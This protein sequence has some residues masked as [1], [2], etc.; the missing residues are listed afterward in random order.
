LQTGLYWVIQ[1]KTNGQ[2]VG[3]EMVLGGAHFSCDE[4]G[5]GASPRPI[6]AFLNPSPPRWQPEQVVVN[7][8]LTNGAEFGFVFRFKDNTLA[9]S[10]WLRD[11]RNE[12][13]PSALLSGASWGPAR[14]ISP[15]T[16]QPERE[17]LLRGYVLKTHE[18]EE[19][20]PLKIYVYPFHL[21]AN[22]KRYVDRLEIVGP[23]GPRKVSLKLNRATGGGQANLSHY[24]GTCP[25]EGFQ[26]YLSMGG[27]PPL[28]KQTSATLTL[29]IE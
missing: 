29:T 14:T 5:Q 27:G 20:G 17:K 2:P 6:V 18:A 10:A 11:P 1:P 13:H 26:C 9:M 28:K 22:F 15:E 4:R 7:G 19:S 16:E 12:E 21:P 23:W 3:P 25:W 8:E 24:A